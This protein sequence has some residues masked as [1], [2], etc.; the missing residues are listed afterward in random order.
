MVALIVASVWFILWSVSIILMYYSTFYS[1]INHMESASWYAGYLITIWILYACYKAYTL[2]ISEKREIRIGL[3]W[4]LGLFLIHLLIFCWFYS[5][6]PEVI[7]SPFMNGASPSSMV[8][9]AHI[10]S[11]LAY[12]VLLVFIARASGFSLLNLIPSLD[13]KMED[14]RIRVPIEVSVGFLVFSSILLILSYFFWYTITTLLITL[15]TVSIIGIPGFIESFRDARD[16]TIILENH[17]LGWSFTWAFNLKLLTIELWI[18]F[19]V[20]VLS[21]SLVNALRPMP[22]GWDDLGVYMNFPKIM[23]TSGELLQW[24]GLY[25]WQLITGTGFLFSYTAAQAFYINQL[26]WILAI[27]GII[28][29]LSYILEES[30]KKSFLSLPVLFAALFY[31][32][33]MTVFQQ[34]KDMKLDPALMFFSISAFLAVFSLWKREYSEKKVFT[35]IFLAGILTGLAFGVKVTSLMLLLWSLWLIAYR[36][37][38]LAGFLGYFFLFIAVFTQFHLWARLNVTVPSNTTLISS[39]VWISSLLGIIGIFWWSFSKKNWIKKIQSWILSSILLIVWFGLALTPWY[40]KNYFE[41]QSISVN[42]FIGGSGGTTPYNF[43]QFKSKEEIQA[44]HDADKN[45]VTS[46][47]QTTNEDLGRY[48]GYDTGINNYLK[49]PANLT[50]QKNQSGEFTEISYIFLALVPSL[51]LFVRS[52]RDAFT[53]FAWACLI[54]L[55]LYYFLPST[56]A[57]I[58]TLLSTIWIDNGLGYLIM[59]LLNIGFLIG[60]HFLLEETESNRKLKE[61]LMFMGIYGFIFMISAFGIVWYGI[62]IYFGFFLIM[63]LSANRFEKYSHIDELDEDLLSG[64]LT[65]AAILFI[66]IA[67]YFIRSVFPHG[68]NNLKAAY[69]NEYKYNILTQDEAIFAYR[70]DYV[71]PIAAL[72]IG[73]QKNT[74]SGIMNLPLSDDIKKFFKENGNTLSISDVH[75]LILQLRKSGNSDLMKDAKTLWNYLY[76]KILYP[77]KLEGNTGGIYRIGTFMTYLIDNNRKRYY[78]DSLISTF[79]KYIYTPSNEETT[80]R[81]RKMGLKYLLIDLNAATIDRDP[82]HDLTNRFERLLLTMRAKN[83]KL[84]DTD[85][86]CLELALDEYHDGKIQDDTSYIDI[87]GTNYESYRS[88]AVIPRNQKLYN[89]HNYIVSKLNGSGGALSPSLSSLKQA[90]VANNIQWDQQKLGQ[91]LTSYAG[92]SWFALFEITDIPAGSSLIEAQKPLPPPQRIAST[93]AILST[94]ALVSTRKMNTGTVSGSGG[95]K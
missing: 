86:K 80:E 28:C 52:R 2:F 24:W 74:L 54:L 14:M 67:V 70:S 3:F 51:L 37:L 32:M 66:F 84:I 17:D 11:L 41:S 26:G 60:I 20:F 63:G 82:R 31:S 92:Q 36:Y 19:I 71:S 56:N 72:N 23:A 88:G 47:W 1:Q 50:F 35:I 83:L 78:D 42:G 45:A 18:F 44:I 95:K 30:G 77:K 69:Y 25:V 81:M 16:R 57:A 94:G 75:M 27:I 91:L 59:F 64:K 34:A 93:G 79:D 46:S 90:I 39:V 15:I 9:F 4:I 49:L 8:L 29:A 68:W 53:Y 48:F 10:L 5:S 76:A 65:L 85:N 43:E 33:P 73:N 55:G 89:C 38:S 58:T 12:P 40:M 87:A 61:V 13:W 6:L 62:V 22:I 7:Q 21:V